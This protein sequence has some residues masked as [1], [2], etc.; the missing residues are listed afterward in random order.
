M[1]KIIAVILSSVL[2]L[3][4]LTAVPVYAENPEKGPE[5]SGTPTATVN[6]ITA[7][8]L[9]TAY[10]FMPDESEEQ[11]SK[12]AYKNYIA[13][14]AVTFNRSLPAGAVK[15]AFSYRNYNNGAREEF[16]IPAVSAAE[17]I[18]IYDR[19]IDAQGLSSKFTYFDIVSSVGLFT[20]GASGIKAYSTTMTV[21]LNL[22]A[23]ENDTQPA[24]ILGTAQ[25]TFP[26]D[27]T[28]PTATVTSVSGDGLATAY[29][30]SP[31]QTAEQAEVSE[32]KERMAEFT[33]SFDHDMSA[34]DMKLAFAA[35]NYNGGKWDTFDIPDLKAGEKLQLLDRLANVLQHP[36]GFSYYDVVNM[37]GKLK[38]GA[39]GIDAEYDINMTVELVLPENATNAAPA[40]TLAK[41]TYK[42]ADDG[43]TE[44]TMNVKDG[45]DISEVFRETAKIAK[46]NPNKRTYK[47]T[48]PK[49][50]YKASSQLKLWSNTHLYMKGVTIK[51]TAS[52]NMLRFGNK[53]DLDSSPVT[54]YNGFSNIRIE[55]GTFDGGGY[56]DAIIQ[57]GHAKNLSLKNVTFCNVKDAHMVEMG[58]CSDVNIEGCTFRDFTGTWSA[59]TNYEALQFEIVTTRGKHFAGYANN[60][61][62][63]PCKNITVKG[64]TFKNLQRGVGSHTGIINSYFTNMIIENNTFV[65]ITGFAVVATNY[66]NS[67]INNNT[68][69]NCG[70][71]IVYNTFLKSNNNFYPSKRK[72]NAHSSY[73]NMNTQIN[74]NT[75][76]VKPGYKAEYK[77]VA[78]GIQLSGKKLTS[79]SDGIPAGD[80]RC[81]GVSV[82]GN[83]INLNSTGYGIWLLG[84]AENTVEN[85]D[86]T[87]NLAKKGNG[88]T[89]DGIRLESSNGNTVNLNTISNI[90]ASGYD[91]G[92][93]GITLGNG[94]ASNTVSNN[95]VTKA[96]KDGIH[97]EKSKSNKLI[98]NTITAAG[99]DSIHSEGSASLKITSNKIIKAKRNGVSLKGA[100]GSKIEKNTFT[101]CK[102]NGIHLEKS[103][104]VKCNKNKITGS[105]KNG[106]AIY[107]SKKAVLT[108]N[109]VTKSKQYGIYSS[110][111]KK[112]AIKK[113]TGNKVSKSGKRAR[114]WKR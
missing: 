111:S 29:M 68:I 109:T 84:S 55:G 78:F 30:F 45:E 10:T 32:Y 48:I 59:V 110:L 2:L 82:T 79:A 7:Q 37:L 16:S 93:S 66:S 25:Y 14:F 41:K 28:K 3:S 34:G 77:N 43:I 65:N 81:S 75:I 71:G 58:G 8:G 27:P 108:G 33:V 98:S 40:V 50:T 46:D 67:K 9:E 80:Y 31:V 4:T 72:S 90:T 83:T 6:Y 92:M 103:D 85:N 56:K 76:E 114:S 88:G 13:D 49:G 101:S 91:K 21:S 62:E 112:K 52:Y 113:D 106:I 94:S 42:F 60:N 18:H 39:S 24:A 20:F 99:R 86:I 1:K 69:K 89:G 26:G 87:C 74:G 53:S 96:K 15:L 105:G 17:E 44:I 23:S 22:Y 100:K 35:T 11:A 70:S 57:V 36:R 102:Q 19:I 47:I 61:D 63:T 104:S 73:V 54:G 95:T 97:I 12:S 64:C 5:K 38:F 51:R 107:S